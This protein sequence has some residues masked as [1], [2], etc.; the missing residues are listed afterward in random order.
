MPDDPALG[1]LDDLALH[2]VGMP[3]PEVVQPPADLPGDLLDHIHDRHEA[4][5]G[6]GRLTKRL[7]NP[8]ERLGGRLHT[9]VGSQS[10][11]ASLPPEGV[12]EEVEGVT[13]LP[14]LDDLRLLSVQHE[15][16]PPLNRLLD[17]GDDLWAHPFRHDDEVVGVPDEPGLGPRGRA[18]VG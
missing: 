7:P 6:A 11:Q 8:F 18:Q 3:N 13:H 15:P 2:A 1:E 10:D 14:Q 5:A 4:P 9:D 16:Q 17:E 12:A